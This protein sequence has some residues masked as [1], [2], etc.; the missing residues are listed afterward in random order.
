[1]EPYE[2]RFQMCGQYSS[3]SEQGLVVDSCEHGNE[4]SG[5]INAGNVLII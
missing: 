4:L 2:N 5:F 3:G 1:M